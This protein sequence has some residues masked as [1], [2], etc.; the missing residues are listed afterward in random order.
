MNFQRGAQSGQPTGAQQPQSGGSAQVSAFQALT[1]QKQPEASLESSAGDFQRR[2][3]L[4]DSQRLPNAQS[5]GGSGGAALYEQPHQDANNPPRPLAGYAPL[6]PAARNQP[7]PL[8]QQ[9]TQRLQDAEQPAQQAQIARQTTNAIVGRSG[10]AQQIRRLPTV[11]A[12]E[13][14]LNVQLEQFQQED[15]PLRKQ[16]LEDKILYGQQY[17]QQSL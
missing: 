7:L 12:S 15:S 4:G 1:A 11:R 10:D 17:Q 14:Q 9:S 3:L 5:L 16:K 8:Q 2:Q 6:D 13:A